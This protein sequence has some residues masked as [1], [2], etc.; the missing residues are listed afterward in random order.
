MCRKYENILNSHVIIRKPSS[1]G[2][3]RARLNKKRPL[4]K[5]SVGNFMR[6]V[7]Y[8]ELYKANTFPVECRGGLKIFGIAGSIF[9]TLQL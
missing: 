3:K 8:D 4:I 2:N 7:L 1:Y 5:L 9:N 6:Y